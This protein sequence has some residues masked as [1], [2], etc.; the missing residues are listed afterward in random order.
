MAQL[1]TRQI[2]GLDP[3]LLMAALGKRYVHPG[4][5]RST[6][7]L[8]EWADVR[9]GERVLDIGCGA[10]TTALEIARRSGAEV[11][12]ADVSPLM[13]GLAERNVRAA[14]VGGRV[15]VELRTS[16]TCPT[17]TGPSTAWSLRR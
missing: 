11:V 15:G 16:S 4:G 6:E 8:L 17:T 12:A 10:G 1:T 7:R 9:P 3:Y 14:G 2:G 5:R 13:R